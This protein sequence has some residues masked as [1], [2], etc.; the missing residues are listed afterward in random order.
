MK[1][2]RKNKKLPRFGLPFILFGAVGAVLLASFVTAGFNESQV[3]QPIQTNVS[4]FADTA[5]D[6]L[7]AIPEEPVAEVPENEPDS[8]T[9]SEYVVPTRPAPTI[10]PSTVTTTNTEKTS[11]ADTA[12]PGAKQ[13]IVNDSPKAAA[14]PNPTKKNESKPVETS[15]PTP[16]TTATPTQELN[17]YCYVTREENAER[18][19]SCREGFIAPTFEFVGYHSCKRVTEDTFQI[20]GLVRMVGGNYRDFVWNEWE[21]DGMAIVGATFRDSAPAYPIDWLAQA[22]FLSMNPAYVGII[23]KARGDGHNYIEENEIS[24]D[25]L[26]K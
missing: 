20:T 8:E 17:K 26:R 1:S 4:E 24:P 18:Y 15:E 19:D 12:A 7:G 25:C 3:S 21:Y 6:H 10:P 22:S 5:L 2:E 23:A 16:T 14:T 13:E 11:S 9:I